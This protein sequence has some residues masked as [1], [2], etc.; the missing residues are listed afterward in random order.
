[1]VLVWIF[2][3]IELIIELII[4]ECPQCDNTH[5]K[6]KKFKKPIK[7]IID[8]GPHYRYIIDLC[9]L[10]NNISIDTG[11]KYILDIVDHFTKWYQGY[12]IKTKTSEEV[13]SCI[14]SYI[15]SCGKPIIL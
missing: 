9:Y 2:K 10:S 11:Y 1:M 4:K 6:F 15:Q 5:N 8:N 3:D 12:C 7:V 13:L 14:E